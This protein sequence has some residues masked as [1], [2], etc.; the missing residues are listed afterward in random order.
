MKIYAAGISCNGFITKLKFSVTI[1]KLKLETPVIISLRVVSPIS[2]NGL[3]SA[4]GT[5]E[6]SF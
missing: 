3:K 1:E 5:L 2:P 4:T 6:L